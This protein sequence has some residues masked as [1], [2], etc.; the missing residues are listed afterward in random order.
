[1]CAGDS[2][3]VMRTQVLFVLFSLVNDLPWSV[4][5]DTTF[6]SSSVPN[7]MGDPEV[8]IE[9]IISEDIMSLKLEGRPEEFYPVNPR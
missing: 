2:K 4:A 6:A 9:E 7:N 3:L 5:R 1:M 8:L